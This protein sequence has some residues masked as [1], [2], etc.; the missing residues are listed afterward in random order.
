LREWWRS[1]STPARRGATDAT[2]TGLWLWVEDAEG[3]VVSTRSGDVLALA[4]G[5]LPVHLAVEVRRP[6]PEEQELMVRWRDAD[7]EHTESAGIRPPPAH[8]L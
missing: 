6:L 8:G 5:D 2:I 4:P 3:N 7:G 1:R